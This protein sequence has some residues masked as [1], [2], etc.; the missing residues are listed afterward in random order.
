MNLLSFCTRLC[1]SAA[2]CAYSYWLGNP[3]KFS[4]FSIINPQLR[5]EKQFFRYINHL[6]GIDDETS[7]SLPMVTCEI[8]CLFMTM[9]WFIILIVTL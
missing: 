2:N 9:F 1:T 3:L 8:G 7:L 4:I 5:E 6:N